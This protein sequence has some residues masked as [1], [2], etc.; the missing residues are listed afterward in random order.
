LQHG[1][2][3][4]PTAQASN[5]SFNSRFLFGKTSGLVD[6]A[7]ALLQPHVMAKKAAANGGQASSLSPKSK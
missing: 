6:A 4:S 5:D 7:A 3:L 2:S 1:W